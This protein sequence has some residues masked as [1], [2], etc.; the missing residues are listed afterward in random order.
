MEG[1]RFIRPRKAR[2]GGDSMTYCLYRTL[3]ILGIFSTRDAA[4]PCDGGVP[5]VI[6]CSR[7]KQTSTDCPQLLESNC[8]ATKDYTCNPY[9]VFHVLT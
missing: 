1:A 4:S 3:V 6:S 9:T 8:S 7:G 5:E 2:S